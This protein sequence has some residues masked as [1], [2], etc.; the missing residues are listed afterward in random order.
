MRDAKLSGPK[1]CPVEFDHHSAA[2]AADWPSI[3]QD[4]R[5]SH[6]HAWSDAYGGF[7]VASR[8]KDIVSIAQ[9]LDSISSFKDLDPQSG[10]ERGGNTIPII[11][12]ARTEP[13]EVDSP[14]W[15]AVRSFLMRLFSP[16]AAEHH[17]HRA[18]TIAAALLDGVVESGKMEIVHD[19]TGPL[20][21]I[22]TVV[23][24][25]GFGSNEWQ[26]FAEAFHRRAAMERSNPQFEAASA[27]LRK[28]RKRLDEEVERR[29]SE[30]KDDLLG[31]LANGTINGEPLDHDRIQAIGWQLF[32][33]GVDT[34][35][36]LTSHA[37]IYLAENPSDRQRLIDD[38]TLI[39]RAC[40]E[41]VRYFS[42]IHG[43]GRNVKQDVCINGIPLEKGDRVFLAYASGNRDPE[44]FDDPET[45]TLDRSPNRHVGWGSGQHRCLGSFF[46]R[47][48][49]QSMIETVLSRI[50]DYELVA[51]GVRRYKSVGY[52]NGVVSAEVR[53][54]PG[55]K[56]G[57]IL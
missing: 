48:M 28:F 14:E 36:A 22:M 40:E 47:M 30:P 42:P 29:R 33:G 54:T 57:A 18:R 45:F 34:T 49:F 3:Y 9:N 38:P 11:P 46:A 39:P 4:L 35:T 53:F 43:A 23:D 1:R 5:D 25:F 50:P 15:D 12:N 27:E 24:I 44:V 21:A 20:P 56:V 51:N 26:P 17:R 7:W 13:G 41:F 16:K 32:S 55:Q 10:E 6:P 19:L 2:H 31:L 52:A 8:Y 37:L